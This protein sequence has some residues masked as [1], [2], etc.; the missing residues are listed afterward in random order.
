MVAPNQH[1]QGVSLSFTRQS[2]R[3]LVT[4]VRT[5]R[6]IVP[7]VK[8]PPPHPPAQQAVQWVLVGIYNL[9]QRRRNREKTRTWT[10]A[11]VWWPMALDNTCSCVG[12]SSIKDFYI[13]MQ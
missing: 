9:R 10:A 2:V 13:E 11:L 4:C 7:A 3:I 8:S 12:N 1:N 6:K 5:S